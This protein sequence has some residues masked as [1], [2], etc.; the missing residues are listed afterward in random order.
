MHGTYFCFAAVVLS[1]LA[2][3]AR[4]ETFYIS[5]DGNDLNDGKSESTPWLTLASLLTQP[6]L[7][8]EIYSPLNIMIRRNA[9]YVNDPFQLE[10]ES[11]HAPVKITTYGDKKLPR[12][13]RSE[14]HNSG[15]Q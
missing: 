3:L 15:N 11:V 10:L 4:S 2:A 9:T 6:A 7:M 1:S 14:E 13:L 8:V 12:P 5:P